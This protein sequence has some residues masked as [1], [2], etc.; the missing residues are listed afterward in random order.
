MGLLLFTF[1]FLYAFLFY[2]CRG[3]MVGWDGIGWIGMDGWC[4]IGVSLAGLRQYLDILLANKK[5][6]ASLEIMAH[7][8]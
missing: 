6:P 5:V 3:M 8:R 4:R 2:I 1:L 7:G